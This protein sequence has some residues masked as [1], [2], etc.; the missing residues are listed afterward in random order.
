MFLLTLPE[1]WIKINQNNNRRNLI[2]M[3]PVCS[4]RESRD[5]NDS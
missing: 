1:K 5:I 2:V 3:S 4:F